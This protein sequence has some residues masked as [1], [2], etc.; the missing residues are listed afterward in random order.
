MTN[1]DHHEHPPFKQPER[2]VKLDKY[3]KKEVAKTSGLVSRGDGAADEEVTRLNKIFES[4]GIL[5]QVV[6]SDADI[7][8][9]VGSM[10]TDS[11]V[12]EETVVSVDMLKE[13]RYQGIFR[14]C[15]IERVGFEQGDAH[16][17]YIL[18]AEKGS[19][20]LLLI[21]I[22]TSDGDIYVEEQERDEVDEI[23]IDAFR[24][25]EVVEDEEYKQSVMGLQAEYWNTGGDLLTRLKSIGI[26]S[27]AL[28]A[29]PLNDDSLEE[30]IGTVVA[31]SLEDNM[32]YKLTGVRASDEVDEGGEEALGVVSVYTP[33][34]MQR[35]TV[36]LVDNFDFNETETGEP[37]INCTGTYQPAFVFLNLQK[38]IEEVFPL[39]FLSKIEEYEYDSDDFADGSYEIAARTYAPGGNFMTHGEIYRE[40]LRREAL[41]ATLGQTAVQD[42]IGE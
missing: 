38:R 14:G 33:Q 10:V 9:V 5:G 21:K 25:L 19:Y 31:F 18:E 35:A 12:V 16:L 42:E 8:F 24:V 15:R 40:Y 32:T 23:V 30:A 1:I 20:D 4:E 29:H 11:G 13:E 26:F 22:L 37:D 3:L 17:V 34:Y 28:L 27:S 6:A 39:R 36:R 41:R 2:W 7:P